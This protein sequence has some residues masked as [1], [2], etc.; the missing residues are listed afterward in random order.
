M[1]EHIKGMRVID[2][3]GEYVV[4][5]FDYNALANR[6][7]LSG[8]DGMK[9]SI[10]S[11]SDNIEKINENIDIINDNIKT[12]SDNIANNSIKRV[13]SVS[14]MKDTGI[15]N[16][17]DE[18]YIKNKLCVH[19]EDEIIPNQVFPCAYY[20]EGGDTTVLEQELNTDITGTK[21]LL[22]DIHDSEGGYVTSI[23][24]AGEDNEHGMSFGDI[25]SYGGDNEPFALQYGVT[26][27]CT[28]S[29]Y[30]NDDILAQ[31]EPNT[32]LYISNV[33]DVCRKYISTNITGNIPSSSGFITLDVEYE[34]GT[35]ES[36]E[37]IKR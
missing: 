20:N 12:N 28:H 18:I 30:M 17:N 36:F 32:K 8:L 3:N 1:A 13:D 15:Y 25:Y 9:S 22:F 2:E 31:Y 21:A 5:F 29:I 7:D 11:N 24:V 35:Y 26:D 27:W 16:I 33:S 37:L 6:P 4:K 10:K 19:D 23:Y 14:D 34:D